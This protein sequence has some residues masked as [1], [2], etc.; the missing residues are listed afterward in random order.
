LNSPQAFTEVQISPPDRRGE[1]LVLA[2]GWP[3]ACAG[4][5]HSLFIRLF[6]VGASRTILLD[7]APMANLDPP[8][9]TRLE[10]DG[11]LVEFEGFSI[12]LGILIRRYVLHYT[13]NEEKVRHSEPIA[14][15]ARTSSKNG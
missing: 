1:R 9:S 6:R 12:D 15:S 2:T 13:I 10:S 4:V 11:L 7:Q 3:P 8:Y 5:W 14:L